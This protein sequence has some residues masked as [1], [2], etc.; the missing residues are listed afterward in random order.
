MNAN[1]SFFTTVWFGLG[2]AFVMLVIDQVSKWAVLENLFRP[3]LAEK[4]VSLPFVEPMGFTDWL[5]NAPERIPFCTQELLP[6]FHLSMVWNDGVSFGLFA[7]SDVVGRALL[8]IMSL[9]ISGVLVYI[10]SKSRHFFEVL[11]AGIVVGGALGNVMDRVRFG[12]VADFL[13]VHW[14]SW[15]FPVFNV[16]DACISIGIAMFVI[17]S[18]F[19]SSE[20]E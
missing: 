18:L 10:M 11:S 7:A 12:A 8:I 4:M 1:K 14:R 3:M 16:A 20:K 17:F 19:Y 6:V 9:V 13:D 2:V 15:Y 5:L